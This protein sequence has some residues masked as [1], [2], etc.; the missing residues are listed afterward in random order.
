MKKLRGSIQPLSY[1]HFILGVCDHGIC[2]DRM[3]KDTQ[4]EWLKKNNY[5]WRHRMG[6]SQTYVALTDKGKERL[7]A[8][9][10]AC[11]L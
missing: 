9:N 3:D 1:K 10:L 11:I 7:E 8:L 4:W 2:L 5:I 6:N